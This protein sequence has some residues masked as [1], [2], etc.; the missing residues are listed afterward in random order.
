MAC[1]GSGNGSMWSV[2]LDPH[3]FAGSRLETLRS[4]V[5][6]LDR[7]DIKLVTNERRRGVP[8]AYSHLPFLVQRLGPRRRRCKP[9]YFAVAV[10]PPP[11]GPILPEYGPGEQG[12]RN[13]QQS[14]LHTRG[15]TASHDVSRVG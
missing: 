4:F 3:L 5:R 9:A 12:Q 7:K 8:Q 10:R 14:H 1:G 2:L 13:D 6:P 11:L 15:I